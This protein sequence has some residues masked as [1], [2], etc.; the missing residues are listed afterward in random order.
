[1]A[2]DGA[3]FGEQCGIVG[4]G[5]NMRQQD[6]GLFDRFDGEACA[7]SSGTMDTQP[8]PV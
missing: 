7:A 1:M 4:L 5:Q 2:A 8:A 3:H 6:N